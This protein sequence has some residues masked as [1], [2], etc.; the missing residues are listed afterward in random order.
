MA[1]MPVGR[2]HAAGGTDGT[3]FY[4]FG[5]RGPGRGN[6]NIPA[7]GF[8]DVMMY[9]PIGDFWESTT[10][11]GSPLARLP[12]ARGGQ[13]KAVFYDGKFSVIGGETVNGAG[14]PAQHVYNRVDIYDPA[15]NSWSLGATMPT[16]RHGIFPIS[17][18]GR[19]YVAGGGTQA[20]FSSSAKFEI[21]TP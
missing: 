14:A 12:Q 13:G 2:N 19:I 8:D 18:L 16:A 7:N 3:N 21:Y 10:F 1:S 9:H 5:G 15:L 4:I 20:G 11:A 17:A 6:T